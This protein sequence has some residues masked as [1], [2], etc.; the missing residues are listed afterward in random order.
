MKK[1]TSRMLRMRRCTLQMR[2]VFRKMGREHKEDLFGDALEGYYI[3]PHKEKKNFLINKRKAKKDAFDRE[4]LA[5]T[6]TWM[7]DVY[8]SSFFYITVEEFENNKIPESIINVFRN[9]FSDRKIAVFYGVQ[10]LCS[11]MD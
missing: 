4:Y 6:Y 7:K 10:N 8:I 1:N 5:K 9:E 11:K 2:E 3:R